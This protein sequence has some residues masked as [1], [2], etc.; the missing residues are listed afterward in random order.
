V[1]KQCHFLT[2][3]DKCGKY[4]EIL[5]KEKNSRFPMMGCGCSSP[6]CNDRR[7]AKMKALG[8]DLKVEEDQMI[9][10]LGPIDDHLLKQLF[11]G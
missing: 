5:E 3:E 2:P 7:E 8:V 9:D 11:P 1:K 4:E 6:L 10:E